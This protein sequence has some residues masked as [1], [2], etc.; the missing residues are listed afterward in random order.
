[1]LKEFP[2]VRQ[3]PGEFR[4]LFCDEGYDLYVWYADDRETII[5]LQL[6]YFEGD[7]QKVVTWRESTGR[8]HMGIDDWDSSRFNRTP[9]LVTDGVPDYSGLLRRLEPRLA[10]LSGDIRGAVLRALSMPC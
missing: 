2:R 8:D 7:A 3:E 5:G 6:L 9:L 1:M 10:E 4:R